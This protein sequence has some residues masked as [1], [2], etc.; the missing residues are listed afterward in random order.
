M[1]IGV[2]SARHRGLRR[3][4]L[5]RLGQ[6]VQLRLE[7]PHDA[8]KVDQPASEPLVRVRVGVADGGGRHAEVLGEERVEVAADG[9]VQL[10]QLLPQPVLEVAL[11][12][13]GCEEAERSML[14]IAC[15]FS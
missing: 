13:R 4:G 14:V 12:Q 6:A 5:G 1:S 7:P 10:A 11:R 15:S 9:G 3:T 2:R 8:R